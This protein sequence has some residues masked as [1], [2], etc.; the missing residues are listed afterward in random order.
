MTKSEAKIMREEI[1]A[2]I[3]GKSSSAHIGTWL[4]RPG[5]ALEINLTSKRN[6]RRIVVHKWDDEATCEVRYITGDFWRD[7]DNAEEF[8]SRHD[9]AFS[10][11]AIADAVA[12]ILP[13]EGDES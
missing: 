2:A 10:V 9:V 3:G 5:V 7:P 11:P 12:A 8:S 6:H 1:S 4:Q 13:K